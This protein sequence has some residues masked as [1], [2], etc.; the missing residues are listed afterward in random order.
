MEGFTLLSYYCNGCKLSSSLLQYN[1]RVGVI[2]VIYLVG[3]S[4]YTVGS[5][6]AGLLTDKL[7]SENTH[8]AAGSTIS[9][10]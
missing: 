10:L 4:L 2:G 9:Y 1:L 6:V 7:V 3:M 5:I 8:F